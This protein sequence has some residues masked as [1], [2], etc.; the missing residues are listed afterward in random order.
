MQPFRILVALCVAVLLAPVSSAQTTT[1]A[2]TRSSS[3]SG[4]CDPNRNN[5][6]DEPTYAQQEEQTLPA[7][8]NQLFV[9]GVKNGGISVTGGSGNQVKL[10]ICKLVAAEDDAAAQRRLAMVHS[11]ISGGDISAVGPDD[12]RWLVHF[13]LTV[14]DGVNIQAEAHNGPMEFRKVNGN[15]EAH[16]INGPLSLSRVSGNVT[17]TAQNGPISISGSS[18]N[19]N[20]SAQ[21]GPLSVVLSDKQ[22]NGQGL[23]ASTHNGPV[24]LRIAKDFASGVDIEASS[25][26]P[27]SC[28]LDQCNSFGT[29]RPWDRQRSV[30]IGGTPT[31]VRLSTV[32]GPVQIRGVR[33]ESER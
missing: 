4:M 20:V 24:S 6:G 18:G 27:I 1:T 12:G 30:H 13:V 19:I 9:H 32:N 8:V 15:I 17:G 25:H 29:S 33:E 5:F 2:I 22:W 11:Q 26:S 28:D 7:G 31:L 23:Q 21:N 10:K 14:P 16:T 3:D